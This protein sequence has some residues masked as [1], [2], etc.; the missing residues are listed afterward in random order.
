M[1]NLQ[2]NDLSY[3]LGTITFPEYNLLKEQA[4]AIA[5][6][7]E[8]IEVDN[9]NV[10]ETKKLLAGVNKSL[11]ELN[12]RR[13]EIKKD[14]MTPYKQFE[15]QVKE[16]EQ[17]VRNADTIVR[18]Q[19]KELE[20]QERRL[21]RDTIEEEW[22]KRT[23]RLEYNK[24]ISFEDFFIPKYANKSTSMNK[25]L[26]EMGNFIRQINNDY[27]V[28]TKNYG[29]LEL[30]EYFKTFDLG[31]AISNADDYRE[32]MERIAKLK[33]EK[34]EKFVEVPDKPEEP[35]AIFI[36]TGKANIILTEKLL[37]ENG[38]DYRKSK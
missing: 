26:E 36:V 7:I 37:S 3:E 30:S 23:K 10:K 27:E 12:K 9:D 13:I 15:D 38:I 25:V 28:I 32:E 6:R 16:I 31:Q 22:N 14:M 20:E 35:E 24:F 29:E 1:N 21:K 11:D 33:E 8:T 17:I 18:D 4:L 2:L 19:V 5:E 34:E